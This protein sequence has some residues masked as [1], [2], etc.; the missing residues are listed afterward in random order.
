MIALMIFGCG[1]YLLAAEC[2][3]ERASTGEVLLFPRSKRP[4]RHSIKDEEASGSRVKPQSRQN[5]SGRMALQTPVH[6][7]PQTSTF[8]WDGVSYDIKI[9]K[10]E[11]RLLNE[12]DGWV[13]PGTLTALMVCSL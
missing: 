4:F 11:R 13:Q 8:H 6:L 2:I 7:Q 12:I 5:G 9:K 1:V 10:E 3:S